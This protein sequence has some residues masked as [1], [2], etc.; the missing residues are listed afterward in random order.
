MSLFCTSQHQAK[1]GAR[2]YLLVV[3]KDNSVYQE[4]VFN[5]H[6]QNPSLLRKIEKLKHVALARTQLSKL[7]RWTLH[8]H[9]A[10]AAI[11]CTYC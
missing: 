1:A 4:P 6:D 8:V 5:V 2:P 10:H 7:A 11:R 9:N 3:P